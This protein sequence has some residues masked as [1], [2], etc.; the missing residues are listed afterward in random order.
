MK[1]KVRSMQRGAA[2]RD[3]GPR[4]TTSDYQNIDP[5]LRDADRLHLGVNDRELEAML[6]RLGPKI[7]VYAKSGFK[8]PSDV[9]RLLNKESIGTARGS[10]WTPRLGWFLLKMHYQRKT[11]RSSVRLNEQKAREKGRAS[12]SLQ[13]VP[14]LTMDEIQRRLAALKAHWGSPVE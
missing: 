3:C 1:S 7:Q 4:D 10:A 14:I 11:D 8:K 6:D 12:E 9:V 13:S 5:V 2:K